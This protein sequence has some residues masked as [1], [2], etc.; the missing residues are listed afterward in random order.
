MI[1]DELDKMT[2]E[3]EENFDNSIKGNFYKNGMWRLM[4]FTTDVIAACVGKVALV[5][6]IIIFINLFTIG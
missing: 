1:I 2:S 6:I 5:I 4:N 3:S